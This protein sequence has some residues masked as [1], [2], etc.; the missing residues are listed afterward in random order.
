MQN[1][2]Y[3]SEISNCD[4]VLMY[5]LTGG[6]VA[7]KSSLEVPLTEALLCRNYDVIWIKESATEVITS[8]MQ[9]FNGITTS[10]VFQHT[11]FKMQYFKEELYRNLER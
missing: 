2:T 8:G 6:P 9:P 10:F 5:V 1:T 4:N 3:E 7:G 11:L